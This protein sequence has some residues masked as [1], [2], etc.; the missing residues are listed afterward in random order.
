MGGY[1]STTPSKPDT[2]AD[3]FPHGSPVARFIV[4]V[5]M[6]ASDVN[7]AAWYAGQAAGKGDV[8]FTYFLRLAVSHLHEALYAI[9]RYESTFEEVRGFKARL[10][11]EARNLLAEA[12][13]CHKKISDAIDQGRQYTFH[14]PH[15]RNATEKGS[16]SDH[17]LERHLE[18]VAGLPVDWDAPGL[19]ASPMNFAQTAGHLLAFGGYSADAKELN[20]QV[21][22]ALQGTRAFVEFAETALARY[23]QLRERGD[24]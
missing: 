13:R 4:S 22:T 19:P 6:G 9:N 8:D 12:R 7:A 14:Y 2:H 24:L 10:P 11:Q 20:D 18:E 16:N 15:P 3:V 5:S 17:L 23:R 21:A 1:P